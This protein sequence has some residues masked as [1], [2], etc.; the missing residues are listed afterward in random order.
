[1]TGTGKQS[2]KIVEDAGWDKYVGYSVSLE[3]IMI[4]GSNKVDEEKFKEDNKIFTYEQFLNYNEQ[5]SKA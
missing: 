4:I 3:R 5:K 1:V 2:I